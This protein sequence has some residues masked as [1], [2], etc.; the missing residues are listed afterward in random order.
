M[1]L[2]LTCRGYVAAKVPPSNQVF[3]FFPELYAIVSSM[4]VVPMELIVS[5]LVGSVLIW[6]GHLWNF[7][8]CI[9]R[10][11]CDTVAVRGVNHR[12]EYRCR[13]SG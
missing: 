2:I 3:Y 9:S 6:D 7:S 4:P 1:C 11:T 13:S 10:K 8:C 12:D 5:L